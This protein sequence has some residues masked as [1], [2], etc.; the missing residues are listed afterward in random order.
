MTFMSTK[1]W[2]PVGQ[3]LVLLSVPKV[4]A[5]HLA[6]APSPPFFE[7]ALLNSNLLV[8]MVLT[9]TSSYFHGHEDWSGGDQLEY[10]YRLDRAYT[11][12]G[13]VEQSKKSIL[14]KVALLPTTF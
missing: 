2:K 13:S 12:P 8:L 10:F 7:N 3:E 1:Y 5:I 11:F 14:I 4:L 6:A 9:V